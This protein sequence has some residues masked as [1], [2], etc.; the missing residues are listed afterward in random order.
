MSEM[1]PMQVLTWQDVREDVLKVNPGLVEYVDEINPSKS[2]RIYKV[3]Y[4]FGS[5]IL[6]TGMLQLVNDKGKVVNAL[7]DSISK[8]IQSDL[9]YTPNMPI[10][11]VLNRTIEL[12]WKLDNNIITY[13]LMRPGRIFSLYASLLKPGESAHDG[14]MWNITAGVRSL[15]LLPKISDASGFKRLKKEFNLTAPRPT[16][17][18]D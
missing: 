4:P 17:L 16:G 8:Q 13:N 3:R 18:H 11:V 14:M 12:Y 15:M 7:D 5:Y 6:K 1:R 2:F 9:I 10:G